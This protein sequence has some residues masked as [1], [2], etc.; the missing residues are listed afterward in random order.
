MCFC[1]LRMDNCRHCGFRISD[2]GVGSAECG[3]RSGESRVRSA[4]PFFLSLWETPAIPSPLSL[5]ERVRVRV[6]QDVNIDDGDG[7]K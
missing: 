5:W 7:L 2:C 6:P 3:L 1:I 4:E